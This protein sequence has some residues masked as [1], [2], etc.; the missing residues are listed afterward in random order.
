[1]RPEDEIQE[2]DTPQGEDPQG[3]D[4][5]QQDNSHDKGTF[6]NIYEVLKAYPG[7]GVAG[8]YVTI[9]GFVHYWNADRGSWLVSEHR[10]AYTDALLQSIYSLASN[11][12]SQVTARL[13]EFDAR[14][15]EIEN[16]IPVEIEP[17]E[18]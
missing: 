15:R 1:M 4:S 12:Q 3:D 11:L 8:D 18:E 17:E 16:S 13:N 10:D 5:Q 6:A 2:Q 14:L 9:H 7:G